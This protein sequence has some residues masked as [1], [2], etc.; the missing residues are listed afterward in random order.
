MGPWVLITSFLCMSHSLRTCPTASCHPGTVDTSK[1]PT[2]GGLEGVLQVI[3]HPTP[4][5][6]PESFH[7]S[8]PAASPSASVCQSTCW[9]GEGSSPHPLNTWQKAM[10]LGLP[11][12]AAECCCPGWKSRVSLLNELVSSFLPGESQQRVTGFAPLLAVLGPTVLTRHVLVPCCFLSPFTPALG[13]WFVP[14]C[15]NCKLP[16]EK[17]ARLCVCAG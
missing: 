9:P 2:V 7:T 3:C 8:P 5:L 10:C 6:G 14:S 12:S 4:G 17:S 1:I 16:G 11:G 15:A 13:V